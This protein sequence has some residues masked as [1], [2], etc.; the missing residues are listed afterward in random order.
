MISIIRVNGLSFQ[1]HDIILKC[2]PAILDEII[3]DGHRYSNKAFIAK[4][5]SL[6]EARTGENFYDVIIREVAEAPDLVSLRKRCKLTRSWVADDL[7]MP[8][9]TLENWEKKLTEMPV[10]V[11]NMMR[12]YYD[13][14]MSERWIK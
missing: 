5:A 10:Y 1:L 14:L 13:D 8:L 3:K 4:Y 11:E 7:D 12:T 9:R 2:D 6:H